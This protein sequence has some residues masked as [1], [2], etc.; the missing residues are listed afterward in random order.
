MANKQ[1]LIGKDEKA[2]LGVE[3]QMWRARNGKTQQEVAQALGVS[4][5]TISR[6]E[7]DPGSVDEKTAYRIYAYLAKQLRVEVMAANTIDSY[8]V[9][10]LVDAGK[11]QVDLEASRQDT[12]WEIQPQTRINS[13]AE[14]NRTSK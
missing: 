14:H 8:Q 3:L 10:K 13:P 1:Q 7:K 4:R 2:V 11:R 12:R 5:W 9:D 6:T